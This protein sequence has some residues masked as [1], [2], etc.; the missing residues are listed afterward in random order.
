MVELIDDFHGVKLMGLEEKVK[1][2]RAGERI[3]KIGRGCLSWCW[4]GC[5]SGYWSGA[6]G[7]VVRGVCRGVGQAGKRRQLIGVFLG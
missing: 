2:A 5:R 4:S 6:C 7:G 3:K 1:G